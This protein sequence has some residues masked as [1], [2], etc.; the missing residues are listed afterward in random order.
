LKSGHRYP[1]RDVPA[2]Q[3][4]HGGVGADAHVLGLAQIDLAAVAADGVP[5][6]AVER[7]NEELDH[8]GHGK[9]GVREN[10]IGRQEAKNGP[11]DETVDSGKVGKIYGIF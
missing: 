7:E 5:A 4:H 3:A 10:G 6:H 8:G 9:G 1:E 2:Q 11:G